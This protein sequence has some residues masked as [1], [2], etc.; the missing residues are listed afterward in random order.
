MQFVEEELK[1]KET[2]KSDDKIRGLTIFDKKDI[3][4][5]HKL[6]AG[7]FGTVRLAKIQI[8]STTKEQ[9]ETTLKAQDDVSTQD[10][11]DSVG[12]DSPYL[13]KLNHEEEAKVSKF[14]PSTVHTKKAI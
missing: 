13:K 11:S 3:K 14:V 7:G 8:T 6:G 1:V 12:S 5:L 4:V 10:E 9:T 2:V